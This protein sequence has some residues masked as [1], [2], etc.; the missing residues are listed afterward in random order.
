MKRAILNVATGHYVVGQARLRKLAMGADFLAWSDA[1]PP[2]SPPHRDVPYAFKAHAI[3]YARL[4]G[5]DLIMWCDA[6][7]MPIRSMEPLWQR[8][9]RDGYW[10]SRNGWTNGQWCSDAALPLLDLTREQAFAQPH[11]VATAFGLNLRSEI[12]L[13]FASQYLRYAQNGA[14]K[15][16]WTNEHREASADKRVLGHRHDQTAASVLAHRLAFNLTE[17]PDVFAYRGGET[18]RTVLV[19]DGA[20]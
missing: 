17:P 9:E 1:L 7:I 11:V 3:E 5:Y 20:Y 12:G 15:G 4:Q 19:A 10:M 8:I 14:Y 13:V 18:E 2:N 6:C 16:P